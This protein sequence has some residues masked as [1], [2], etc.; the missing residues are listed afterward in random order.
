MYAPTKRLKKTKEEGSWAHIRNSSGNLNP[1]AIPR[2][3][4]VVSGVVSW[5]FPFANWNSPYKFKSVGHSFDDCLRW[6]MHAGRILHA[7][8]IGGHLDLMHGELMWL[9]AGV[10]E[11]LARWLLGLPGMKFK[12]VPSSAFDYSN[13]RLTPAVRRIMFEEGFET[14]KAI[15]DPQADLFNP[16]IPR[17][18][19]CTGTTFSSQA[20]HSPSISSNPKCTRHEPTLPASYS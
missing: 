8:T 11:S 15:R 2:P 13:L 14:M 6:K 19:F 5:H 16:L 7:W 12:L 17:N 20:T 1:K 18:I 9:S 10:A 3:E 4:T